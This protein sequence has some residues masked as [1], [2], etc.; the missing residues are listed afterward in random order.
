PNSNP[1]FTFIVKVLTFNRLESVTRCLRSLAAADYLTDKVQLHG[2]IDHF[3]LRDASS[4][5]GQKLKESHRI[6]EFLD[7]F[8]WKYGDKL[9]HYRTANAGLRAQWLEAWWP[10]SDNEF[11]FVV[12][13]DLEVSPLYYKFLRSLIVNYYYNASNYRPYIYGA[14]LQRPRF[15]PVDSLS[16]CRSSSLCRSR[17]QSPYLDFSVS[18]RNLREEEIEEL[19]TLFLRLEHVVLV[20]NRSDTRAWKLESS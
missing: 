20:Q 2:Y 15:V 14:S 16:E 18:L 11:A 4:N 3:A 10:S 19:S 12:E 7:G 17:S 6:L 1:N 8:E 13:D 5:V 9:I